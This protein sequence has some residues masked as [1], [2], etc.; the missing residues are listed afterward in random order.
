MLRNLRL[1]TINS[2]IFIWNHA[3]QTLTDKEHNPL[4][5]IE[6]MGKFVKI[7]FHDKNDKSYLLGYTQFMPL[8]TFYE[9]FSSIFRL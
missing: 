6:I 9:D 5:T 2:T 7:V 3:L 1:N 8:L 4:H